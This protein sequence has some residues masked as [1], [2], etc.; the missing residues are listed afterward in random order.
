M[1]HP[2]PSRRSTPLSSILVP[3]PAPLV[4][5][6]IF[7][8][9]EIHL[10]AFNDSSQSLHRPPKQRRRIQVMK[11]AKPNAPAQHPARS[12]VRIDH[13]RLP[14]VSPNFTSIRGRSSSRL[15][16]RPVAST[17]PNRPQQI[18]SSGRSPSRQQV[19]PHYTVEQSLKRSLKPFLDRLSR[20]E[21]RSSSDPV[22]TV[23]TML[24]VRNVHEVFA[25]SKREKETC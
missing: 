8:S 3:T 17:F 19:F 2:I 11:P 23:C 22:L 14:R 6:P 9:A 10:T 18:R 13:N 7:S 1:I 4:R 12:S 21:R 16:S 24:P 5:Q 25:G 20:H 15:S